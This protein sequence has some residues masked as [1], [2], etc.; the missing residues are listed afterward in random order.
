M[1][2]G[3]NIGTGILGL[4]LLFMMI[5]IP[6]ALLIFWILMIID[7]IKRKFK[8]ESEKIIWILILIFLGVI[9]ATLYYF[10]IKRKKEKTRKV[11]R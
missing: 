7:C 5:T 2:Q 1:L 8:E 11:K 4:I 3:F 10:I 9:G 6:L